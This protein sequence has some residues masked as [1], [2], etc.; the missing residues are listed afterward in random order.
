MILEREFIEGHH[1]LIMLVCVITSV[2]IED[3]GDEALDVGGSDRLSMQ[4]Q[5]GEGLMK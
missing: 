2:N 1:E 4:I 5:K 3:D